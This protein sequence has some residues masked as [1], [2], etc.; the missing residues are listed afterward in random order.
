MEAWFAEKLVEYGYIILFVWSFME[1]E[2]GLIMAGI[3]I[4]TGDMDYFLAITIAST[5]GFLG[6]QFYFYLGRYN[7]SYFYKRFKNQRRKMALAHVLLRKYGWPVI[8]VQRYLYGMR[9]I[10]P[11]AIGVTR[12]D[13][14][15]FAIINLIS[16]VVWAITAIS[17]AYYFG[18]PLLKGVHWI[19]D[20]YYYVIPIACCLGGL[21]YFGLHR[22]SAKRP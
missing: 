22:A 10:I 13:A 20:H 12:Y 14:R 4:H 7:K 3:M 11:M 2:M 8:F 16:A 19:K 5:G 15:M 21:I 17:L 1:G 18:E 9:A 6:D